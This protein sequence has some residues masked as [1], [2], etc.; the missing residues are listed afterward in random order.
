MPEPN[1]NS[2]ARRSLLKKGTGTSP[3]TLLGDV[4]ARELGASPLFQQAARRWA[5]VAIAVLTLIGAGFRFYGLG[6]RD[7]WF[8]ESCTFIYV[9]NLFDWPE[10]SNLLVE[11]TNLPYYFVL[12]GWAFLFGDSE[13]GYR[14]LSALL[15]TLT[16]PLLGLVAVRLG[17]LIAGVVCAAIIA[18]H[19][20]HIHYSHEARAYAMWLFLLAITFGLLLEAGRRLRWR[21]WGGYG[22][23]V[24]ACLHLHYFTMYWVAATIAIVYLAHDRRRAFGRWLVTNVVVGV[25]FI[26]YFL[27]AVWPAARGGGSGWVSGD[28]E[29]LT[30]IPRTLWAFLPAGGYPAHLRGL[31]ILSADTVSLGPEWLTAATRTIPAVLML[32]IALF[33]MRRRLLLRGDAGDNNRSA[34][35][36]RHGH[37]FAACMTLL[38]LILG[39]GYSVLVQPNYLVGRYDLVAWPACMV[40]LALLIS[41]IGRKNGVGKRSS[42]P[43][44]AICVPLLA[45]SLVPI[46]RMAALKAEPT[47]ANRRAQRL[48][49]LAE[50]GD[51]AITFSYDRD[52]LLYYLHRAG[53]TGRIVGF[54]S[55]LNQQ[56]GWVDLEPELTPDKVA[57]LTEDTAA[58]VEDVNAVIEQGSSVW[59]LLDSH[60]HRVNAQGRRV[61]WPRAEINRFLA[62]ALADAG[63]QRAVA[64]SELLISSI[65]W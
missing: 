19:P 28:W 16:I 18:F 9:H 20:L 21:W 23:A 59:L 32:P 40:W 57:S 6:D 47:V 65:H 62:D 63:L 52:Y 64:D 11:S 30:A 54:P 29:P 4:T 55:W 61:S 39:W 60:E 34:K 25:L 49:E 17:G 2:N 5:V 51:L 56:V 53:F 45:C 31:S 13:V 38:P 22:V 58:F 42:W 15:G 10:E 14:S 27:A 48:A 7:F 33:L 44:L 3:G 41:S 1:D 35:R 26:P 36:T 12:R 8:D 43:A 50:P 46:A 24:L 37:V